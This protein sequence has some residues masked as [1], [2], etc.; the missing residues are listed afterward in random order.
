M[1]SLKTILYANLRRLVKYAGISSRGHHPVYIFLRNLFFPFLQPRGIQLI[2]ANGIKMYV[3]GQ[4]YVIASELIT[5]GQFEKEEIDFICSHLKE[6]HT[7]VDLG[8]NIGCVALKAAQKVGPSGKVYAF[9]PAPR[10]YQ[11]LKQ[12]IDVNGLHQ[13]TAIPQIVSNVSGTKKLYLSS[14]NFGA[15]STIANNVL[16]E[17]DGSISVIATTLDD[18]FRTRGNYWVDFI[19]MD[20]QG[21]EGFALEG[22]ATLLQKNPH[23]KIFMEFWPFGIRNAGQDPEKVLSQMIG[24]GFAVQI[25]NGKELSAYS[26]FDNLLKL[27]DQNKKDY[28]NLFLSRSQKATA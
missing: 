10:N 8:A 1:T 7:V 16:K 6:G 23:L 19:K 13:I 3:D 26:G 22:A 27:M 2:E 28:I 24:L 5:Y 15:H 25:F 21:A 12:N 17:E 14:Q 9:E 4:D 20:I 18:F 11:L